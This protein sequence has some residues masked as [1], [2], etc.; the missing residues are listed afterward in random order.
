MLA[1]H[2]E[3]THIEWMESIECWVVLDV[4]R[5]RVEASAVQLTTDLPVRVVA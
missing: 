2:R 1:S 5:A 3:S 4:S